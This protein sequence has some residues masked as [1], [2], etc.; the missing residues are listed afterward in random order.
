MIPLPPELSPLIDALIRHDTYP[1]LVGGYVRDALL[2]REC[3]D[4][5]I[6][7]YNV[8]NYKTLVQLLEPFGKVITVGK[9]FGVVKL[10]L[11][12]YDLDISLPR[13]E[14]KK[15]PGHKGFD[16]TLNPQ[17]D[18]ATAARRRDF[19]INAM[20]YDLRAS[21]LLD[22]Y[23]GQEDL[24]LGILRCVDPG[25]FVE[26]PLR[27]YRAMQFCA[28]FDL[29]CTD[30]LVQVCQEMVTRGDLDELPK[31]RIFEE[32]KKLLLKADKPS[33]GL[34]FLNRVDGLS[35]HTTLHA[36]YLQSGDVLWHSTLRA[37][38][39]MAA[40]RTGNERKDMVMMLS[41]LCMNMAKT[42]GT[43]YDAKAA[44][45]AAETF[46]LGITDD[47]ELIR[48]VSLLVEYHLKPLELY[49]NGNSDYDIRKLALTLSLKDLVEVSEVEFASRNTQEARSFLAGEWLLK[50]ADELNAHP[51][52]LKP[53]LQGRDLVA[54]GF[55]P[56]TE[57]KIILSKAYKAQLQG[58]FHN[59]EGAL[60]WFHNY[61]G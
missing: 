61:R 17:L 42:P 15:A 16:I 2:E 55:S 60:E 56:S 18:F 9:S 44:A 3:K 23:G 14:L 52:S 51:E 5:D 29:I 48:Q 6:E 19:T 25:T 11:E 57:F 22:P 21:Y 46:L 54:A 31:E 35:R 12:G 43:A 7:V 36:I 27:L 45:K 8:K 10:F 59:K 24:R 38:D 1:V 37:V 4:I 28:R 47:K 49:G 50:R 30:I 13:T 32:F 33:E 53:L 34:R 58:V 41:A 20:G 26:D 39:A 40:N